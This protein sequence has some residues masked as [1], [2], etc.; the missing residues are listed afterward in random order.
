MIADRRVHSLR[1]RATNAEHARRASIV[2]ED[3][4]RTATFA[5]ETGS[6]VLAIRRLDVGIISRASAPSS[7]AL[8]V[9]AAVQRMA[10]EAVH[11][12]DPAAPGASMVYFR[13]A[14]EPI[15][16]LA[17]A[18]AAGRPTDAWFW[19]GVV[20]GWSASLDRTAAVRLLLR[21]A[22]ETPAAIVAAAQIVAALAATLRGESVIE[23]LPAS[24]LES[25]LYE[26]GYRQ[27]E[28]SS[29][30]RPAMAT[31][32]DGARRVVERLIARAG[33]DAREVRVKWVAT[34]VLIAERPGRVVDNGLSA[35]VDAL[36]ADVAHAQRDAARRSVS[37]GSG[38]TGGERGERIGEAGKRWQSTSTSSINSFLG[39]APRVPDATMAS[40]LTGPT[41][42]P[43]SAHFALDAAPR[44][45][46]DPRPTHHAGFLFLIPLLQR[47]GISEVLADRGDLLEHGWVDALLLRLAPHLGLL[48]DDP[49]NAWITPPAAP[50]E[51]AD[52]A[53]TATWIRAMRW[54]I[55]RDAAGSLRALVR[56]PGAIVATRTHVDVL[57]HFAQVDLAI[58]QAGLDVD[59]GWIPW[60]GRVIQFHYVDEVP[61]AAE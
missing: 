41:S 23:S 5:G 19:P 3:A 17:R 42:A 29:S 25:M 51:T 6:R 59:P 7:V 55:K 52:R 48:A 22:M 15:V 12:E 33:D 38:K 37:P 11:G 24:D 16:A 39:G 49:A 43:D 56:R 47:L 32:S 2:L 27:T 20:R 9:E 53:F 31:V 8:A 14:G 57:M 46:D 60:L 1:L 10:A 28:A 26:A 58:R 4:L 54:R 30:P 45:W 36:V 21:S 18:I 61:G 44:L 40:S 13:D 35:A 50:L 34:M